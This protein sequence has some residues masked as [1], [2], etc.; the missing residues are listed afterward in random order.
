MDKR[1]QDTLML[2][3]DAILP[4]D[5]WLQK[6]DRANIV[7][8]WRVAQSTTLTAEKLLLIN[9]IEQL[10]DESDLDDNLAKRWDEVEKEPLAIFL[11][12]SGRDHEWRKCRGLEEKAVF[13]IVESENIEVTLDNPEQAS[14]RR[15][16]YNHSFQ[17]LLG[18]LPDPLDLQAPLGREQQM[19]SLMQKV[20]AMLPESLAKQRIS[21]TYNQESQEPKRADL[22]PFVIDLLEDKIP[23]W[24]DTSIVKS[25]HF[26]KQ[27][28]KD[29]FY[30]LMGMKV[31]PPK[32]DSQAVLIEAGEYRRVGN[33]YSVENVRAAVAV[34][35]AK[36]K[37]FGL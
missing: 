17:L 29:L 32:L 5:A 37:E 26:I 3:A 8:P 23:A 6:I 36:L 28:T 12:L 7:T 20:R 25:S 13:G 24:P 10:I 4:L 34:F 33:S 1:L 18:A 30:A 31:Q 14:S 15:T 19:L 27:F 22:L 9:F 2:L 11:K 16:F 21:P 35:D